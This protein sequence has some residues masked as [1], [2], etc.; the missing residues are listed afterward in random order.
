MEGRAMRLAAP[1]IK[2]TTY[3]CHAVS[4]TNQPSSSG[5]VRASHT[6]VRDIDAGPPGCMAKFDADALPLGMLDR[7]GDC[8]GSDEVKGRFQFRIDP[9][10]VSNHLDRH[11]APVGERTDGRDQAGLYK[12]GRVNTASQTPELVQC[13]PQGLDAG[14]EQLRGL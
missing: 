4:E 9:V 3:G 1:H 14:V 10:K 5:Q 12:D 11:R 7:V 13:L 6:I 2:S 8:L